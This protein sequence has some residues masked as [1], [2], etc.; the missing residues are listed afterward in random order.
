[1]SHKKNGQV[2]LAFEP[3]A[4]EQ[5]VLQRFFEDIAGVF[6]SVFVRLGEP[7][8]A[9]VVSEYDITSRIEVSCKFV[10]SARIFTHTV[11]ELNNTL[12]IVNFI[13]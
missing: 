13:P 7:V 3:L 8:R 9:V 10:V 4:E 11:H 6:A 5:L 12:G 2:V 1:M